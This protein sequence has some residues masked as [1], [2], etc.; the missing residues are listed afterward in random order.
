MDQGAT[1]GTAVGCEDAIAAMSF[2]SF[3]E[4]GEVNAVVAVARYLSTL[5]LPVFRLSAGITLPL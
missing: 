4:T 5:S 1:V 3:C 2:A